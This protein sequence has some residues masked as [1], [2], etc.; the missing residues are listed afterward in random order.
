MHPSD[1]CSNDS[2]HFRFRLSSSINVM[3][4]RASQFWVCAWRPIVPII[5]FDVSSAQ[6]AVKY[7]LP[8]IPALRNRM[9]SGTAFVDRQQAK[10][11]C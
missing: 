5:L 4:Q 3:R 9:L 1:K 6:V 11:V 10:Y 8:V 2:R 7:G